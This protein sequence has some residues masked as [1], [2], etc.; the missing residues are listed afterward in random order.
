MYGTKCTLCTVVYKAYT[1]YCTVYIAY[2]LY[3]TV[4]TV[5]YSVQS[6]QCTAFCN[7]IPVMLSYLIN[8]AE[9]LTKVSCFFLGFYLYKMRDILVLQRFSETSRLSGLFRLLKFSTNQNEDMWII[10]SEIDTVYTHGTD[11]WR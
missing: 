6:V 7:W 3:C 10:Q 1:V 2:T 4:Y 11:G 5:L 9:I 8:L